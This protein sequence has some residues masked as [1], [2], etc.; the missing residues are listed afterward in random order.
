MNKPVSQCPCCGESMKIKTLLCPQ[1][2]LE[3]NNSFDLSQFDVLSPNELTFLFAFLRH[4]GNLKN[5]QKELNISYPTAKKRLDQLLIRL[6]LFE[7]E[8]NEETEDIDMSKLTT[9]PGSTKPS[10]IIKA[11]L[12]ENG[13]RVIVHSAQGLPCEVIAHQDGKSFVSNKLP[14]KPAYE[15]TVFDVIVDLLLKNGGSAKKGNGR[16]YKVGHPQCDEHTVVGI[17]A[18]QYMGKED[19]ESVRDPVFVLAAILEWA[20]IVSNE[21]GRLVLTQSY[22]NM[23]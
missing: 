9:D 2:G 4:R 20:G 13:G 3:L 19:G 11:K 12:A 7:G 16:H 1:C 23:L 21:R 8:N 15:Y 5:L 17:I 14:V 10:E 18:K 22:K 6:D